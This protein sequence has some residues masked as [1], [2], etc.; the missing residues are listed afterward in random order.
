MKLTMI[1]IFNRPVASSRG[2]TLLELLV[3]LVIIGLLAS[4]VGPRYFGQLGKSEA[5]VA[6]A[7]LVGLEKALDQYRLDTGRYPGTEAGMAALNERPQN[8]PKWDGPYLKGDLPADPWGRPYI[9]RVPGEKSEYDLLSLGR[10]GRQGGTGPDA[11]IA[12]R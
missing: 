5:K 12:A 4:F 10:D 2:F 3:V 7:Q 9:Y 6:K 11:D 8:E 1:T